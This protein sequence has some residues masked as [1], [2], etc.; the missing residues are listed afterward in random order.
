MA[1]LC[2][3]NGKY[4]VWF[5]TSPFHSFLLWSISSH[6]HRLS[7]VQVHGSQVQPSQGQSILLQAILVSPSPN[8]VGLL[9]YFQV[10]LQICDASVPFH[11][12]SHNI[13]HRSIV[14][15][16][17]TNRTKTPLVPDRS[18]IS[19]EYFTISKTSTFYF[20]RST[21]SRLAKCC[22]SMSSFDCP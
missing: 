20:T 16:P 17:T 1:C 11:Y 7:G 9:C 3:V 13:C 4:W 5:H 21:N 2:A 6:P 12:A 10:V 8:A 22:S 15:S 18:A 14:S 19:F